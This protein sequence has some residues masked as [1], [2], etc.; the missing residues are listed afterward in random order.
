MVPSVA[1]ALRSVDSV[2]RRSACTDATQYFVGSELPTFDSLILTFPIRKWHH[3]K[4]GQHRR[5][6]IMGRPKVLLNRVGLENKVR[7][8]R[9]EGSW[10]GDT[11]VAV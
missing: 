8:N 3:P 5:G 2:S 6:E 9:M 1:Q 11:S 7:L 10:K 4:R